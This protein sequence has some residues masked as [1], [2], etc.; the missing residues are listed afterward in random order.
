MPNITDLDEYFSSVIERLKCLRPKEVLSYAIFNE[1][2]ETKYYEELA[3]RVK[4]DSIK[5]LFIQM[6]DE[7]KEHRD[8]LYRLFKKLYTD[9]EPVKV[10]VPPVEV[11]P[12][13]SEFEKANDYLEALEYCMKSELFAKKVYE[14]LISYAENEDSRGIFSQL[15]LMERDHYLRIRKAY[16]FIG[17][18]MDKKKTITELSPGGYLFEDRLKARYAFLDF[19][20]KGKGIVFS[21]KP[22]EEIR[23]WMKRNIP[24]VWITSKAAKNGIITLKPRFIVESPE[25]LCGDL[26]Q[27]GYKVVLLESIESLLVEFDE[28]EIAK[29]LMTMKDMAIQNDCYILL[30]GEKEAF[31]PRMWAMLTSEMEKL[32]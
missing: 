17:G 5:V 19:L 9:E 28:R 30:Q 2:E 3:R 22:P 15:A 10:D 6:S 29:A 8:R 11:F 13:Y 25:T 31:T 7:S 1:D 20:S 27:E 14:M 12:Y 26:F 32:D 24:V 21:R 4:R 16:E 18:F 23:S